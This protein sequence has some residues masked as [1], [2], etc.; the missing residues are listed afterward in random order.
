MKFNL[1]NPS[2]AYHFEADDLEIAAV[3][4]C[5]LGAGKYGADPLGADRANGV[6][7]FI[8]GGHDAWFTERFGRSFEGTV[9]HCLETRADALARAFDSVT[10]TNG[11]RSSLN[12]IGA[13]AREYAKAV[14][15]K[16]A[17]AKTEPVHG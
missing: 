2:D 10:L 1:I 6:P 13:N 11:R 3:M 14:R 9:E 15:S 8:F 4:V 12:N 17:E 5:V 16:A 7:V